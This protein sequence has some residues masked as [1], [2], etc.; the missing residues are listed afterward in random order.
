MVGVKV[1]KLSQSLCQFCK[2]CC[3]ELSKSSFWPHCRISFSQLFLLVGDSETHDFDLLLHD[4]G[5]NFPCAAA[6]VKW[7]ACLSGIALSQGLVQ[8][9]AAGKVIEPSGRETAVGP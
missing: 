6:V 9:I 7:Y 8:V 2:S 1:M 3:A 5:K 4:R